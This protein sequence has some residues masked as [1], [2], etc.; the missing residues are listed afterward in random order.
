[1]D[2]VRRPPPLEQGYRPIMGPRDSSLKVGEVGRLYL[3]REGPTFSD[4]TGDYELV[5]DILFGKCSI[6]IRDG[7][8]KK[9]SYERIGERTSFFSGRPTFVYIPP[10]CEYSVTLEDSRE[11][12]AAVSRAKSSMDAPPV[13]VRPEEVIV[14]TSGVGD[15]FRD[16]CIGVSERIRAGA[17]IVG[18]TINP[19]GNWSSFPPHKHDALSLPTEVPFEEIYYCKFNPPQGFGMCRAYGQN[20]DEAYV[21]KDGYVFGVPS[22]YHTLSSSP[23]YELRYVWTLAGRTRK[24]GAWSDDPDHKWMKNC[25]PLL[26]SILRRQ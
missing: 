12:E 20:Y 6:E 3:N 23:G 17:L 16:I 1:L 9:Y 8:G 2:F 5:F 26:R 14:T 25:E 7:S 19:P 13:L 4:Q 11:V 21:L 24:L 18:E 22:Q 10:G 15:W